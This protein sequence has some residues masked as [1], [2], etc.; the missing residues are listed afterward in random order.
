MIYTLIDDLYILFFIFT[1]DN[2]YYQATNVI[3]N[4]GVEIS[5]LSTCSWASQNGIFTCPKKKVTCP[6][7]FVEVVLCLTYCLKKISLYHNHG[8]SINHVCWNSCFRF[9]SYC[10]SFS[11]CDFRFSG[12][13]LF[14][15]VATDSFLGVFMTNLSIFRKINNSIS[16]IQ[17]IK[18]RRRSR[19][20]EKC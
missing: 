11:A 3:L 4:R 16:G 5:D 1:H 8:K 19:V 12:L 15:A 6:D 13:S 9:F 7:F 14:G 20:N 17:K 10:L 2:I 18:P